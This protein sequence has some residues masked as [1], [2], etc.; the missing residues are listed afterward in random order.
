MILGQIYKIAGIS[1]HLIVTGFEGDD[2]I[3]KKAFGYYP[4]EHKF[5]N[6]D[7]PIYP[8][9]A[10]IE[11]NCYQ[12]EDV[13]KLGFSR[14]EDKSVERKAKLVDLYTIIPRKW[15]FLTDEEVGVWAEL[16]KLIKDGWIKGSDFTKLMKKDFGTDLACELIKFQ[17]GRRDPVNGELYLQPYNKIS[18]LKSLEFQKCL[19]V[20]YAKILPFLKTLMQDDKACDALN[21]FL[22]TRDL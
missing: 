2:A 14:F 9:H 17:T 7:L 13:K 1:E 12:S 4:R 11:E 15:M 6:I 16:Q 3:L 20:R 19:E 21:A 18:I 10:F 5:S 8:R 22:L